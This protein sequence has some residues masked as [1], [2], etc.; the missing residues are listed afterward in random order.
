MTIGDI[1]MVA[2]EKGFT[3]IEVLVALGVFSV[4]LLGLEKMHL[5]AIQ[6]NTVANRLTQATTLAQDRVER[7][8]AMPYNDPLLADTTA[9]GIPTSYPNAG[10]PDPSPPPQGYTIRWEVD[11][12]VPSAG[13]KTINIFV[14]WNNLRASKTFSLSMRKSNL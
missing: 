6:V 5:T 12:D 1:T 3:L 10:H 7:F 8:M 9:K 2:T 13:I 11:T 4:A 14:T